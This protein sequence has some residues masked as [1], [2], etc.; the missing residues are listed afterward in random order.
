MGCRCLW[1]SSP[2][3]C[4][5]PVCSRNGRGLRTGRASASAGD[6]R[7]VARLADGAAGS[8]G[9]GEGHGSTW[10]DAGPRV[11]LCT[12]AGRR[13]VGRGAL[14]RGLHL[15]VA[16]EF[17]YQQGLPH[18]ATY[19][20]KHALIQETAYQS[21]LRST[22][23]RYHQRIAQVLEARFP[24]SCEVQPE[25]LAHH[26]TEA[27]LMPRPSLT[28]NER[29]S[30][31]PALGHSGGHESSHQGTRLAHDP[32]R[33]PR[34]VQQALDFQLTLGPSFLATKGHPAPEFER[35][36][37]GRASSAGRWE[38]R[39]SFP[40]ALGAVAFYLARTEYQRARELGEQLLN[41]AQRCKT[42]P[43]AAGHRRKGVNA[44]LLG[45][46][47]CGPIIPGTG[48]RPL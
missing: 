14:Q 29:V 39:R 44:V 28:G 16:A 38:R 6:S 15:L 13:P 2:R 3:W 5:S 19:R 43:A 21:L 9:D 47:P 7:D 30:A 18:Q 26:Y 22:R 45:R 12:A 20:F 10:G 48:N 36:T 40:G 8:P 37:R 46:G 24:E 4:W 33:H 1:K 17:L 23:Q 27:G 32:R 34:R 11:L 31:H 25:L 42:R 35:S 41:L